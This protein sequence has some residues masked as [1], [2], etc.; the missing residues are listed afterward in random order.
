MARLKSHTP[1][2]EI[3]GEI[4]KS[5]GNPEI[6]AEIQKSKWNLEIQSEIQ[7]SNLKSTNPALIRS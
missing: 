4:L 3:Q 2:Q 5:R 7:K 1:L 6:H